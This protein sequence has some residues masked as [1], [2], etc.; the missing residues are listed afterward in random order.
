MP[1]AKKSRDSSPKRKN[2][3]KTTAG[4]KIKPTTKKTNQKKAPTARPPK[5]AGTAHSPAKKTKTA[6]KSE[7]K[8]KQTPRKP[9]HSPAQKTKAASKSKKI[10][11]QILTVLIAADDPTGLFKEIHKYME[12]HY[13]P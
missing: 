1:S 11:K 12:R 9:A 4:K 8:P 3:V 7:K 2:A 5:V 6:S 13:G 10:S